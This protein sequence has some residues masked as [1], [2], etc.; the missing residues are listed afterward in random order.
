MLQEQDVTPASASTACAITTAYLGRG[1]GLIT[2]L[3]LCKTP[4]CPKLV[5]GSKAS[6]FSAH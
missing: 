1:L 3:G 4:N 5:S 2:P 6:K